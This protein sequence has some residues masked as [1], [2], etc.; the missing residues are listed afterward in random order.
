MQIQIEDILNAIGELESNA[1]LVVDHQGIIRRMN[2]G[3]TAVLGYN[4][5]NPLSLV[6]KTGRNL[7]I[8]LTINEIWSDSDD[9]MGFLGDQ[10]I[11]YLPNPR[12]MVR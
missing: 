7:P 2:K 6:D 3:V 5:D 12:P 9:L 4:D 10:F 8:T 1:I 11:M